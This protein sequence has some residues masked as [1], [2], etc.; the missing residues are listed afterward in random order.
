MV[1]DFSKLESSD[2][3]DTVIHPRE[4]Y[5][6]LIGRDKT[7]HKYLRD[8]QTEVLNK[9]FDQR[10]QKDSLIKMNTGS[11]KTLIGLLILKSCL[12][13]GEGPAVYVVPDPYLVNQ[14]IQEAKDLSISV[15]TDADSPSFLRC[16]DILVI[17]VH[18]LFNGQSVFGV[19]SQGVKKEIGSIIVDDAHACIAKISEQF[20]LTIPRNTET[21]N[22]LFKIFSDDLKGES[23]STFIAI[24]DGI[25]FHNMLLP[26]WSWQNRLSDTIR[27]LNSA[28][29]LG[30]EKVF[31]WPLVL[32]NLIMADCVFHTE[33]IEL[34]LRSLP[35]HIINS[36]DQARRRLIMSATLPDD[37]EIVTHLGLSGDSIINAISPQNA[38]DIGDR[39]ILVPQELNPTIGEDDIKDF[40][41]KQSKNYN[42]VVIVPSYHRAEFWSDEAKIVINKDNID[43]S[44]SQLK[45]GHIGLVVIVN[46]YDGIDLPGDAC[47][48]LVIDGLPDAR[49]EI[50]KIDTNILR[51]RG[52]PL[53]KK[54]QTIEQGMGRGVRSE[55]DYSVVFLMGSSLVNHLYARQALDF[56]TMATK[57]QLDLSEK[58]S[59]QIRNKDIDTLKS[60]I[61]YSLNRNDDW[62][63]SN[64]SALLHTK[65]NSGQLNA[66]A[67]YIKPAFDLVEMKSFDDAVNIVSNGINL[68]Q[69]KELKGLLKYYMASLI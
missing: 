6:L 13:E 30:D 29:D 68:E 11:G 10:N 67:K 49:S 60:V 37:S 61:E 65:Y 36:F 12:N 14:V 18:K 1:I 44:V 3:S 16:K 54:I 51:D 31:K 7:K 43:S 42:V 20:T 57:A 53:V 24:E 17:N 4:I 47:R 8:V 39:M 35:I 62:I 45:G 25:P 52:V 33:G 2:S 15:T 23:E 64:K 21:F 50:N 46:K 19:G 28:D 9:W 34:S 55:D 22:T 58:I 27:I 56:F 32:S 5:S 69:D 66:F 48:I 40:L 26:F 41:V 63:K 59:D 38:N